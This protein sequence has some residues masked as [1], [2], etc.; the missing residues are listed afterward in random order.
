MRKVNP[1]RVYTT[2]NIVYSIVICFYMTTE[3]YRDVNTSR[4]WMGNKLEKLFTL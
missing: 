2:Y 1:L 4:N 3:L